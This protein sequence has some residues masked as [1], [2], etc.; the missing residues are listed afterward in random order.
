MKRKS[1]FLIVAVAALAL[2]M[3]GL[4]SSEAFARGQSE[5]RGDGRG[6]GRGNGK[7]NGKGR[8]GPPSPEQRLDRLS[9]RLGLSEDQQAAILPVLEAEDEE[10]RA[11]H[12]AY[13]G[14]GPEGREEKREMIGEIHDR[15]AVDIKARLTDEQAAEFDKMCRKMRERRDKRGG[16]GKGGDGPPPAE[17]GEAPA[18]RTDEG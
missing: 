8:H 12:E 7:G 10:I 11:I 6:D 13:R 9:Y 1:S 18:S 15:Y 3:A 14:K 4:W 16:R 17:D 2:V 5:I